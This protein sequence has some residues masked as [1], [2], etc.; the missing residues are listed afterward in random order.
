MVRV[1]RVRVWCAAE[2]P[3]PPRTDWLIPEWLPRG[4]VTVLAVG[5]SLIWIQLTAAFTTGRAIPEVGL[6][7]R[8]PDD[9][10]TGWTH[11]PRHRR[12]ERVDL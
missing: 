7:E 5:S 11:R 4:V 9:G 12:G 3:D 2:L 10:S 1:T 6:P 8:R